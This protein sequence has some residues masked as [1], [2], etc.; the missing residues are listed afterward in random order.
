MLFLSL[1]FKGWSQKHFMFLIF[2]C[3]WFIALKIFD[4]IYVVLTSSSRRDLLPTSLRLYFFESKICCG[5]YSLK[6]HLSL[7]FTSPWNIVDSLL[8]LTYWQVVLGGIC[9]QPL[10]VC[11]FW[12]SNVV[13]NKFVSLYLSQFMWT[14]LKIC[15]PCVCEVFRRTQCR[16]ANFSFQFQQQLRGRGC[17]L[18]RRPDYSW[19]W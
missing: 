9:Y 12:W 4:F 7:S 2:L 6:L 5:W 19:R 10:Y 17:V 8:F 16:I 14:F 11:K 13:W 1:F 3:N 15:L 18:L